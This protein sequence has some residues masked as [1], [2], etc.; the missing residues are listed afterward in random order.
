MPANT[1]LL[2]LRI[3]EEYSDQNTPLSKQDIINLVN[4]EFGVDI[5]EKVF[6]RK[7]AE[8]EDADFQ[9]IKTHGKYAT[10]YLNRNTLKSSEMLYIYSL[11]KANPHIS[12]TETDQLIEGLDRLVPVPHRIYDFHK[13]L[14]SKVKVPKDKID[15]V[16]K[17]DIIVRSIQNKSMI[18]YKVLLENQKEQLRFS[19]YL[20][21]YPK[22][23]KINQDSFL[24]IGVDLEHHE[25]CCPL[26]SIF[27]IEEKKV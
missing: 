16:K 26:E 1:S 7:I 25:V 23:Y 11:I 19:E 8:L 18:R 6:Y 21:M 14:L 2:L 24:V 9:I 4:Q 22:T 17:F 15:N 10:Y 5:S 3:L 27:N 12:E 20:F 13:T